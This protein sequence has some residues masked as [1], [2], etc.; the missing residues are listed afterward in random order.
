VSAL[1]AGADLLCLGATVSAELVEDV[2]AAV[3]AAVADGRLG[4]GRVEEAASRVRQLGG[5]TRAHSSAGSAGSAAA[6]SLGD[7]SASRLGLDAARRAVRI[8]GVIPDLSDAFVVQLESE[9]TIAEGRVPWGILPHV[10]AGRRSSSM[11]VVAA[12]VL[13]D[14][15][16]AAAAGRPMVFA[17]RGVH[18]LVG[19][20]PL[21]ET[22]AAAAPVVVV[23]MG[24]PSTQRPS[25]VRAFVTTY[26]ASR[27]NARAAAEALH[28]TA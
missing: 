26:G 18:R 15:V 25:G 9:R 27:A 1:A 13:P 24:W 28:L 16:L 8:D 17:A 3:G 7:A 6:S 11:R 12:A 23:E 4:L 19:A 10:D 20:M 2:V 14:D 22:V 5:W 21:I